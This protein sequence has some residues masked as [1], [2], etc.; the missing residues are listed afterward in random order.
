MVSPAFS[1]H[2]AGHE[3]ADR[4]SHLSST[5][6]ESPTGEEKMHIYSMFLSLWDVRASTE[7]SP[8]CKHSLPVEAFVRRLNVFPAHPGRHVC[9]LCSSLLQTDSRRSSDTCSAGASPLHSAAWCTPTAQLQGTVHEEAGEEDEPRSQRQT[10]IR[11]SISLGTLQ[12]S[13]KSKQQLLVAKQFS[14]HLQP[15]RSS[16]SNTS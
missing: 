5:H 4:S 13:K 10:N 6:S 7:L 11:K 14:S 3:G 2:P 1:S 9:S 8:S 16:L 15:G 12:M